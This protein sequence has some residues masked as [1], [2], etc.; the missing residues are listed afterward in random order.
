VK[1]L[2]RVVWDHRPVGV[3][4]PYA[5]TR[6]RWISVGI[7]VDGRH[8]FRTLPLLAR[9]D[10][11]LVAALLNDVLSGDP[12]KGRPLLAN[13]V[14][15]PVLYGKMTRALT[16]ISTRLPLAALA[17]YVSDRRSPRR[18]TLSALLDDLLRF[19]I[20]ESIAARPLNGY[21]TA[22]SFD[23]ATETLVLKAVPDTFS[24]STVVPEDV[25]CRRL[26][27]D[28]SLLGST[29][30]CVLAGPEAPPVRL[31]DDGIYRFPSLNELARRY[32]REMSVFFTSTLLSRR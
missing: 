8:D 32:P 22:A 27:W 21:R 4:V 28:H 19:G 31:S 9:S 1:R 6:S 17:G 23:H 3:F 16:R 14:T 29:V 26:V 24:G 13:A 5:L 25:L 12:G 20:L 7:G 15:H 2:K 30:P 18:A 11:D 10:P